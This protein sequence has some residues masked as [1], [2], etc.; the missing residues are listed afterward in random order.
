MLFAKDSL[1]TDTFIMVLTCLCPKKERR[2]NKM[3]V[4]AELFKKII[5]LKIEIN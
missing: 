3:E 1:V 2:E 5:V 4:T